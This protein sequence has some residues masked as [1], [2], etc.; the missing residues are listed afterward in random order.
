[1][2]SLILFLLIAIAVAPL[3]TLALY[4]LA[5]Y[6]ELKIATQ[7][8]EV[9]VALLKL[10][11]LTASWINILGGLALSALG[12]WLIWHFN[13]LARTLSGAVLVLFG[14]W[15]T[16]RGALVN[17]RWQSFRSAFRRH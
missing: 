3:L 2:E 1:M 12:F 4:V 7:L 10:Q 6:F 13:G 15:R 17:A 8:L 14:F 9:M 5:D 16:Y 11:W